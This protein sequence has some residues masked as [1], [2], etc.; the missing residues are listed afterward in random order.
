[1][2]RIYV[3]ISVVLLAGMTSRL[4]GTSILI[5]EPEIVVKQAPL[6]IELVV[7]DI[8]FQP[9]SNLSTGEAWITLSVVRK[10]VGNCPSEI[11]IRRDAVT[12]QLHFLETERHDAA[13]PVR[14]CA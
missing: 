9:I 2:K 10:P 6:I 14:L 4:T 3:L 11:T 7:K 8:R 5:Q 1:M 12:P 13:F